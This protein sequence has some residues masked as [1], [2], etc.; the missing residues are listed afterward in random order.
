MEALLGILL[1]TQRD[2]RV[3]SILDDL[4]GD[5]L[6]RDILQKV[7]ESPFGTKNGNVPMEDRAARI[8]RTSVPVSTGVG[9]SKYASP[10]A[11][12]QEHLKDRLRRGAERSGLI[13]EE[14]EE[15]EEDGKQST[16]RHL[17]PKSDKGATA[18]T[19][20]GPPK[21]SLDTA[22]RRT[23]HANLA[24]LAASHERGE[25]PRQRRR[26]NDSSS[27][28]LPLTTTTQTRSKTTPSLSPTSPSMRL[29]SSHTPSSP[30]SDS[31]DDEFL[32]SAVGQLSLNEDSQVRYH[33]PLSG[34][35]I[36]GLSDRRDKRNEGGLWRFPKAGVWPR[37]SRPR[38]NEKGTEWEVDWEVRRR[39]LPGLDE[40]VELLHLYWGY[41]HPVLPM[42]DKEA[43]WR[44]FRGE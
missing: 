10:S 9:P 14:E 1:S 32:T 5:A 25:S 26:I 38:R 18:V 39:V 3:R 24:A 7:D 22:L 42:L 20:G 33:G 21:L 29:H 27:P 31:S 44:A 2:P 6:A 41:V 28:Q 4:A 30:S 15:E 40:Q 37:A 11:E 43:F 13:W 19:G 35:H 12:W 36:L 34:L 8:L 16:K 17:N 23:S